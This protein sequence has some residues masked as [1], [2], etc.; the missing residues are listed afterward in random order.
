M[1][2]TTT[3]VNPTLGYEATLT[4]NGISGRFK[5]LG[6]NPANYSKVECTTNKDGGNRVYTKGL[7]DAVISG[8]LELS[9]DTAAASI[10]AIAEAKNAVQCTFSVGGISV[11]E[12]M[13]VFITGNVEG[14]MDDT[15]SIP[16]ECSPAPT[17]TTTTE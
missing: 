12:L 16:I 9:D 6:G 11:S 8:T 14:G 1:A 15:V 3:Q 4:I 5:S 13:H 10:A 2:T 7:K 17:I